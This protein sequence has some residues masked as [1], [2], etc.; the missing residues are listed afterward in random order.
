MNNILYFHQHYLVESWEIFF[1]QGNG[2]IKAKAIN[3]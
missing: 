2:L 3:N 1:S